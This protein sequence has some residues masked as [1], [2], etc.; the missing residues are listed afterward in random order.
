MSD[1]P[2]LKSP[3]GA[4]DAH[5]HFYG[6]LAQYPV[7]QSSPFSPPVATVVAYGDVMRRLGIDRVVAVQPAA[8]AADNRCLLSA[9]A[10]LGNAARG[11]AVVA[12]DISD[13]E[14]A[15]LTNRGIRGVR[16]I[17]LKGGT[18]GFDVLERIATRVHDFGWHIQLQMDGRELPNH[19]AMLRR[20]PGT[21]VIDHNGKFLEP[22]PPD[23]ES[24]KCLLRLLDTGR[25]WV[26]ASAPYET[27]KDGPP[28]YPDVGLIAK[29]II[30]SAPEHILWA[31]NWPHGGVQGTKPS[32]AQ[33]LDVLLDWAPLEQTRRQILVDN[34]AKLY[35]FSKLP[36]IAPPEPS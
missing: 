11:V 8:Y 32:D 17:M 28:L 16:F 13:E 3:R 2:K 18:Q 30:S 4:C 34:P 7:A 26:K 20:L 29:K 24:V 1:L 15:Y 27:S 22:V 14:L 5:V 31:T 6:S 33:L 9:L 35:G 12:P 19:E 23:H 36:A 10:E 21:L 25:C